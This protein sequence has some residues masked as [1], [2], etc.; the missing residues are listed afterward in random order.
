MPWAPADP[1]APNVAWNGPLAAGGPAP[2]AGPG[3]TV[4]NPGDRPTRT[5]LDVLLPVA[6]GQAPASLNLNLTRPVSWLLASESPFRASLGARETSVSCRSLSL[7]V[8]VDADG[9][10]P[11]LKSKCGVRSPCTSVVN[12]HTVNTAGLTPR[13]GFPMAASADAMSRSSAQRSCERRR[14]TARRS[15]GACGVGHSV[16][17]RACDQAQRALWIMRRW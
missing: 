2:P 17:V 5:A 1:P 4:I 15:L 6:S 10:R 13:W 3:P 11:S 14:A 12:P 8:H 7:F 16:R 9:S